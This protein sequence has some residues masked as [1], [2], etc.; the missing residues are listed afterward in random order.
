MRCIKVIEDNWQYNHIHN[1][2]NTVL[3]LCGFVDVDN[4][5]VDG[6]PDCPTC[7]EVV[8]YCKKLRL[9]KISHD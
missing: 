6:I 5:E 2:V 1:V 8:K 4:K 3:T 9:G 7:I